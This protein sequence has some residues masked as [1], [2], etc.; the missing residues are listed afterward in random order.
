MT[1]YTAI[2]EAG[3]SLAELLRAGLTPEP[4][5]K[6]ENIGLCEPQSP[7]D[8][9]LTIWIYNVEM[10]KDSGIKV[11]KNFRLIHAHRFS[12]GPRGPDKGTVRTHAVKAA[13]ACFG[14]FK[15]ARNTE[16]RR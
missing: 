9:Q 11:N 7:E 3:E 12:A 6:R 13:C 10:I 16:V 14:A 8:F 1:E 2:Y 15:G 5:L 4:V